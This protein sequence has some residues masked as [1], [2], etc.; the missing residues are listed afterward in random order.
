FVHGAVSCLLFSFFFQY[1]VDPRDLPSFPTRRSSD[2]ENIVLVSLYSEHMASIVT[3]A[4]TIAGSFLLGAFLWTLGE[5]LLQR[6]A[7]RRKDRKS[8]RLNSSH[9]TISYA[10]FCLKK[11]KKKTIYTLT[12]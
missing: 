2:L 11:K 5:Y 10:V 9:R 8:T 7:P 6:K 3:L 4:L 1:S 12:L